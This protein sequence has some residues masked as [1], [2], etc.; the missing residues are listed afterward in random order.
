[1]NHVLGPLIGEICV[2]DVDEVLIFAQ[3]GQELIQ[4]VRNVLERLQRHGLC[5]SAENIFF[6]TTEVNG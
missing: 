2:V 3:S 4:R 6:H 5:A 1:M